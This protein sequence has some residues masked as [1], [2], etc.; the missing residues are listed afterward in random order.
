MDELDLELEGEG[1]RLN[2]DV[3]FLL[4]FRWKEPT[5]SDQISILGRCEVHLS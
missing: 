4:S 2:W 1:S 3:S 5:V